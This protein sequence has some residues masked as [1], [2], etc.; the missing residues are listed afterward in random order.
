M[1]DGTA[2]QVFG[3][4]FERIGK[5]PPDDRRAELINDIHDL[6]S[7]YDFDYNEMNCDEELIEFGIARYGI[8]K[9][10]SEN[11]EESIIYYP[12]DD[13]LEFEDEDDEDDD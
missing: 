12:F 10:N 7:D 13:E 2:A 5:D 4:I 6:M 8:H 3:L 11:G 9:E 1:S